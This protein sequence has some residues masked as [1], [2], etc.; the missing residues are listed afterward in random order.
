MQHISERIKFVRQRFKMTQTQFAVALGVGENTIKNY[1][2]INGTVPGANE[3]MRLL[4]IDKKIDLV[5][6]LTG[7]GEML[8]NSN[9]G[10]EFN[11]GHI[12]RLLKE[13]EEKSD[14]IKQLLHQNTMLQKIIDDLLNP[15]NDV[16]KTE[17]SSQ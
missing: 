12:D 2:R 6:L 16:K 14:Y 8:L 5:W 13:S 17:A 15:Q 3:L 9:P 4:E 10:Q 1:E 11:R 7:E